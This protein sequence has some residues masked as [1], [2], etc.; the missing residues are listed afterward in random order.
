MIVALISL[1]TVWEDKSANQER[2]L[3]ALGCAV[4]HGA[5]L[6]IF[7]EMT[8]TGFTMDLEASV[9]SREDPPSLAWYREVARKFSIALIAGYVK[10]NEEGSKGENTAV[11]V[12]PQGEILG[13]YVK[14]H[15]FSISGEDGIFDKGN[16]LCT[17]SFA[18]TS[19]GLSIC[20]DLRFPEFYQSLSRGA[21]VVVNIA[22]WP[23]RRISHWSALLRSRAIENQVFM[24][25]VNRT[26]T[27][28][29]G[30][31]FVPSSVVHDPFGIEL[32]PIAVEQSCAIYAF[33]PAQT[34]RE[35]AGF[36]FKRDR[37]ED[38]YRKLSRESASQR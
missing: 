18:G 35:R 20:Y 9:E 24:I 29:D 34:A 21:E 13:S 16:E 27:S 2:V 32:E 23:S 26:G 15:L 38:L 28:P 7:P 30:H 36:P 3:E 22:S 33:D 12:S 8:L 17:C 19:V 37:R 10:Y 4:A 5:D 1:D 25:G 11:F 14:A 6:A 31:S